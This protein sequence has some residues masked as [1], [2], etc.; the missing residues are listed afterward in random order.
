M[1]QDFTAAF[2]YGSSEKHIV[3]RDAA[4]LALA[5]IQG[6]NAKLEDMRGEPAERAEAN[7]ALRWHNAQLE[8]RLARLEKAILY[9]PEP[10]QT[11][12]D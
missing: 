6:L 5:D 12:T 10:A 4:G 8:A 11:G 3:G 9:E 2:G 1:A 7:T